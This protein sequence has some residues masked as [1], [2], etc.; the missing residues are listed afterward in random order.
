MPKSNTFVDVNRETYLKALFTELVGQKRMTSFTDHAKVI[1]NFVSGN[2]TNDGN[3][4]SVTTIDKV[5]VDIIP[6]N[7]DGYY[8]IGRRNVNKRTKKKKK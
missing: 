8:R 5:N 1:H 4:L 7:K 6:R 3:N 2:S